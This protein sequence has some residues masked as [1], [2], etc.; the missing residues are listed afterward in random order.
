[1]DGPLVEETS[2]G[3]HKTADGALGP[4]R[5][6]SVLPLQLEPCSTTQHKVRH[7]SQYS[8]FVVEMTELF[9][10]FIMHFYHVSRILLSF[11]K[12]VNGRNQ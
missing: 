6:H 10:H 1:M 11:S 4:G 12:F 7:K 8:T 3:P 2:D 5:Q 9:C